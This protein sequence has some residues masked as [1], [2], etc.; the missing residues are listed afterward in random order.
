MATLVSAVLANKVKTKLRMCMILTPDT[1]FLMPR[2]AFARR[3]PTSVLG[4][5]F[6]DHS[7]P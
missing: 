5:E 3:T 2:V 4:R 7:V 1:L 6:S